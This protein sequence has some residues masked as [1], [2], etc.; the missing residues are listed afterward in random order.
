MDE[1]TPMLVYMGVLL[2]VGML[3]GFPGSIREV[4][5]FLTARDCNGLQYAAVKPA[6]MLHITWSLLYCDRVLYRIHGTII[7]DHCQNRVGVSSGNDPL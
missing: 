3:R 6:F 2:L 5:L 7:M 4:A 1:S